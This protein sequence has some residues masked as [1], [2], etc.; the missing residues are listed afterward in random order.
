MQAHAAARLRAKCHLPVG[1]QA[2]GPEPRQQ[3]SAVHALGGS[4]SLS[5]APICHQR[6]CVSALDVS[7]GVDRG[8]QRLAGDASVRDS[9]GIDFAR[10]RIRVWRDEG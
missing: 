10:G 1:W 2:G 9:S 8:L 6:T 7:G 5:S 3:V 4:I